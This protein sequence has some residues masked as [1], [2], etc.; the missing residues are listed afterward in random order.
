MPK[1]GPK[2]TYIPAQ[3]RVRVEFTRAD[4]LER[5]EPPPDLLER[6]KEKLRAEREAGRVAFYR[7][8]KTRLDRIWT[9]LRVADVPPD[10]SVAVTLVTG[11]PPMPGI[12]VD[13]AATDAGCLAY[14]SVTAAPAEVRAWPFRLFKLTV[15]KGL[16]RL[17]IT[18]AA[19][20]VDIHAAWLRA[21][22]GEPVARLPLQSL[23]QLPARR[24]GDPP[25][26]LLVGRDGDE[27]ALVVDDVR[28]LMDDDLTP[29][30]A[31]AIKDAA[32]K[33]G[34]ATGRRFRLLTREIDRELRSA[35]RGPE[36]YG[37][38]LP[39]VY[40]AAL[41]AA[42]KVP[43]A[44]PLARYVT[45]EIAA[46]R[47]YATVRKS[48]PSLFATSLGR[49]LQEWAGLLATLGV[50]PPMMNAHALP[51]M[52]LARQTLE[53]QVVAK[54]RAPV[55][56]TEPSLMRARPAEHPVVHDADSMR[57]R[58]QQLVVRTGQLV[59]EFVF[60]TPPVPGFD[61]FGHELAAALPDLPS[62]TIGEG[63]ATDGETRF[64]A[65]CDGIP[66]ISGTALL[67]KKV[68][69]FNGSVN[70]S[71]GNVHFRGPATINGTVEAGAL[72]EIHGDLTINGMIQGGTVKVSGSLIV[73]GGILSGDGAYVRA[74]GAITADFI[75]NA[76]VESGG[77]IT[78][79]RSITASSIQAAAGVSVTAADG[80]I[81]GSEL[82]AGGDIHCARFGRASGAK[83]KA[84]V[85]H[86]PAQER[87]HKLALRRVANL[88]VGLDRDLAVKAE[89]D[90]RGPTQLT[91]SHVA[92]KAALADRIPRLRALLERAKRRV[93]T[94]SAAAQVNMDAKI[95][96]TGTLSTNCLIEIAGTPV[97]VL[98]EIASVV[99]SAKRHNGSH[100][101]PLAD[102]A[103]DGAPAK[104]S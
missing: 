25:F 35:N 8:F 97:A 40:L 15:G 86:N 19:S 23:R 3:Y 46:D 104:A 13:A 59:A 92:N 16:R 69:I 45:I 58:Q 88:T 63:I 72:V 4:C 28:A 90:R 60:K 51:A 37:V 5:A 57:E 71:V 85:G 93:V 74:G 73:T 53:G 49:D 20:A 44:H 29:A 102:A 22:R 100:I 34:A 14:L 38:D 39:F 21:G 98:D 76:R 43:A 96:V 42:P 66:E 36:R 9:E 48:D 10:T 84:R 67:L 81:A 65:T 24:D 32:A 64:V 27:I 50:P 89:L 1:S 101:A 12:E 77:A 17:G 75:E 78:V 61:V 6:A 70:L 79:T 55:A 87:R 99:V 47:M 94:S 41:A 103:A 2:I 52:V 68:L 26:R 91:K 33:L 62:V 30:V 80:M 82:I 54:G 83:T 56:G 31:Q 7:I 95:V 11:A 18:D